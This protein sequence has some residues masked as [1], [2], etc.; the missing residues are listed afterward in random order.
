[1]A[2]RKCSCL[3]VAIGEASVGWW[4]GFWMLGGG[5]CSESL[6]FY[7]L[8]YCMYWAFTVGSFGLFGG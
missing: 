1:M 6:G 3:D 7:F 2:K 4:R 8:L 5:C